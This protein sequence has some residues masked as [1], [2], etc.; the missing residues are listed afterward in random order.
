M[1]STT[2]VG[3]TFNDFGFCPLSGQKIEYLFPSGA[4]TPQLEV[5]AGSQMVGLAAAALPNIIES[6]YTT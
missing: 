2:N 1:L 6:Q 3:T 4:L 5:C